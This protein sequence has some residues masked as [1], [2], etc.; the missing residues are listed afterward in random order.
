MSEIVRVGGP[1]V[2]TIEDIESLARAAVDARTSNSEPV[3]PPSSGVPKSSNDKPTLPEPELISAEELLSRVMAIKVKLNDEERLSTIHGIR[4]QGSERET[5][6]KELT[7]KIQKAIDEQH[8]AEEAQKRSGWWSWIA[9]IVA[10]VVS[11]ALAV[12]SGGVLACVAAGLMV[13]VCVLTEPHIAGALKDAM[14]ETAFGALTT[15]LTV[16]SA[17]C[18]VAGAAKTIAAKLAEKAIS[19][20][21]AVV[22]GSLEG[23]AG[24]AQTTEAIISNP[25]VRDSIIAREVEKFKAEHPDATDEEA[26]RAAAK[27]YSHIALG[28]SIASIASVASA[29][30]GMLKVLSA[31]IGD[32]LRMVNVVRAGTAATLA[33]AQG[34]TM[35]GKGVNDIIGADHQLEASN[36]QADAADIR[37]ILAKIQ[38]MQ[39]ED[40]QRL[41]QL[42][43]QSEQT[44][45]NIMSIFRAQEDTASNIVHQMA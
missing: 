42:I 33:I 38:Q 35:V 29:G 16:A 20:V 17:L 2:P 40:I 19:T 13:A 39:D 1:S 31:K 21:T 30:V 43:E 41:Q 44:I 15:A 34:G 23:V 37:K 22:T 26:Q 10:A 8:E 11:V 24:A 25:S 3:P 6:N 14:G 7:E 4:Q 5:A 12:V 28:L 9:K 27:K 32:A 18:S 45:E 36:A